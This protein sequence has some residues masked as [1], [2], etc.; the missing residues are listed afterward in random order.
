MNAK[1]QRSLICLVL[2]AL[3]CGVLPSASAMAQPE[4][5][6][7]GSLADC[8][9][10]N[11]E[12]FT[13]VTSGRIFVLT[14]TEP[15]GTILKTAQLIQRQFAADGRPSKEPMPLVW[16]SEGEIRDGDIVLCLLS[17]PH[18]SPDGYCL[19]VTDIVRITAADTRGL[20]Y[21]ANTLLKHLRCSEN[22]TIQGFYCEDLPDTLQ[23]VVSL[24][25]GRKYYSKDWIC[26]FIREMSWMGYNTLEL[27][28]SDD[29]GFRVDIWDEAYY[30]DFYHPANDFSWICGSNYTSWTLSA[31]QNDPDQGKFLTAGEVVEILDTAR[32]YGID[33]IPAFDSPS[34]LDYLTWTY[35]HNYKI[36]PQYSFY[37]T[38]DRKTYY[39][40]D[41]NG[42]INYTN[43]SGWS[44]PLQWPY[45]SAINIVQP[46]AKAFVFELYL[47]IAAFFK[48]YSGSENFSIGADEVNLNPSNLSRGYHFSWEYDDFVIYINEL[49]SLLNDQGYT[50]RMYNDFMGGTDHT[51]SDYHFSDNI[52]I[53]YWDSPFSPSTGGAGT[54]T[55]P[56]SYYIDQGATL[57]NCIQTNTYYVL[58]VTK[59][60][61]DARSVHNRQ[62]TFYHS[63][64]K[65]IYNEWYPADISEHGD[66]CEDTPDVPESNLGGGYFLIWG[67]YA[68]VNTEAE[69]WNGCYNTASQ[70]T[71]E[72]Y[73]LRDRMWSNAVKMWNWDINNGVSYSAFASIRDAL[74]DFPGC[75]TSESACS[76]TTHLPAATEIVRVDPIQTESAEP[77]DST[78]EAEQEN[79]CEG[80]LMALLP[81]VQRTAKYLVSITLRTIVWLC[82]PN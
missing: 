79:G 11:G 69:I 37:S 2:A 70:N 62:W 9:S 71:G 22:N 16:G 48:A 56:V 7:L 8:Y 75:G 39:A 33:V 25:C 72:F 74:G 5:A 52:E 4:I 41:A 30:T 31:Y 66:Y 60:G 59:D 35:E 43:S 73:S 53:L 23:R 26:N 76:E 77:G 12:V 24:D 54:K 36:N 55:E 82:I 1:I 38:Y 81:L 80:L 78:E 29:S 13:L 49:N 42:M 18:I 57:Y 6:T 51:A 44:T 50:M 3:L 19:D 40:A 28:F 47:D 46:Q 10:P 15:S 27:H 14:A 65:D 17:A 21:G 61:S 45:Y 68:S 63:N 20:L 32:E 64:E 34:H 58:R 67:D